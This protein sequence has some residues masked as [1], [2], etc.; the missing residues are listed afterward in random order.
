MPAMPENPG[1]AV[2]QAS[3]TSRPLP[4]DPRNSRKPLPPGPSLPSVPGGKTLDGPTTANRPVG[5]IAHPRKADRSYR[6]LLNRE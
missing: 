4:P 5:T 2:P 6:D 3:H 1:S